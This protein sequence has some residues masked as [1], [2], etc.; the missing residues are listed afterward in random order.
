MSLISKISQLFE[1]HPNIMLVWDI[2]AQKIVYQ[3]RFLEIDL[4]FDDIQENSPF[5]LF[6][7]VQL[8]I[9]TD[10][11]EFENLFFQK[12]DVSNSK[13]YISFKNAH[14]HEELFQISV[15]NLDA[16]FRVVELSMLSLVYSG[17]HLSKG[18]RDDDYQ[19]LMKVKTDGIAVLDEFENVKYANKVASILFGTYPE[20]LTG[21]N[22]RD[23][24]S[25]KDLIFIQEETLKRKKGESSIYELQICRADQKP[26]FILVTT[27]PKFDKF[28]NF[29]ETLGFFRDITEKKKT[30]EALRLEQDKIRNVLNSLQDL[31]FIFNTEGYYVEYLQPD[32]AKLIK[33]PEEFIGK[34]ISEILPKDIADKQMKAIRNLKKSD[35][36][37]VFDYKLLLDRKVRW[38]SAHISRLKGSIFHEDLYIGVIRDITIRKIQE[39]KLKQSAIDLKGVIEDRNKLISIMAHDLKNPFAAML[40]MS[41]MLS[42]YYDSFSDEKRKEYLSRILVNTKN[43]QSLL[44]NTLQWSLNEQN[45]LSF[46]LAE[47]NVGEIVGEILRGIN[48]MLV[49]KEIEVLNNIPEDLSIV[50]DEQMIRIIFSN[51]ITNAYKFS[52]VKGLIEVNFEN[53]NG[54]YEF[55]V[56]DFGIGMSPTI[57]KTL[58]AKDYK[59]RREG[60]EGEKGTGL[61]LVLCKEFVQRHGGEIWVESTPNERTSFRFTIKKNRI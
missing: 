45:R 34:H 42:I 53:E 51:L 7:L 2:F 43:I 35:K 30:E 8:V 60:T 50:A 49:Q 23:F 32:S 37:Q 41:E 5:T 61:G 26:C 39:E 59:S 55:S 9:D 58:F 28:G 52:K 10:K 56:V 29:I 13:S 44:E 33:S 47:I 19:S 17:I 11:K 27:T 16:Q 38:F 12:E 20:N 1:N 15:Y 6:S 48:V 21:R 54:F 24:L 4:G 46:D 25:E 31:I 18:L 22:F 14:G 40:G 57:Q 36:V 3:N